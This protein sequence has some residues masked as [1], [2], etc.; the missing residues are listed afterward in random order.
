MFDRFL[1]DAALSRLYSSIVAKAVGDGPIVQ[2]K[3]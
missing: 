3:S 2:L 1:N